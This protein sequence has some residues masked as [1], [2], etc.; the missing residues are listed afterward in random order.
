M[1]TRTANVRKIV[2]EKGNVYEVRYRAPDGR[3]RSRTFT[4][5]AD[6]RAFVTD[7]HQSVKAGDWVAPERSRTAW[8]QVAADWLAAKARRGLKPTTL[9]GYQRI[10]DGWLAGWANR[11]IGNLTHEDV[12]AVL[13]ALHAAGRETQ[14]VH[15]VFN[16]AQSVFDYAHKRR[17]ITANPC[18]LVREDLPSRA[19]RNYAPHFLTAAEVNALA[20]AL[21]TPYDLLVTFAAWSGLRWGEVAGLRV[22]SLDPLRASV[23]VE[24]T[25]D[26]RFGTGT[27]KSARSRRT[28][29][30]PPTLA[31]RLADHVAT[32]GLTPDAYLFGRNGA[33]LRRS[34]FYG[35]VFQPATRKAGLPGVRF[36]DLRH[37]FASLKAAQGYSAREVSAW[38]GHGSVSFTLDTY[39]HLF[40]VDDDLRNRLDADFLASQQATSNLA[41]LHAV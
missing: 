24:A 16:V 5:E 29:P 13:A 19:Q 14:T 27:P 26:E 28:V 2:R 23:R 9:H 12:E 11:Q 15:N 10:L 21:P 41:D 3:R 39:T 22:A 37:T 31:R 7:V 36:H 34:H 25:Y 1:A 4:K 30:L 35:R 18:R 32:H 6:A 38:M 40:P 8:G 20:G 17:L 33:P